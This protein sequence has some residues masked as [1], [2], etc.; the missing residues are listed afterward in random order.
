MSDTEEKKKESSDEETSDE[1]TS[2]SIDTEEA[3]E[4]EWESVALAFSECMCMYH[5][6]PDT[7]ALFIPPPLLDPELCDMDN[8]LRFVK[9]PSDPAEQK[10]VIDKLL[11]PDTTQVKGMVDGDVVYICTDLDG[12][13]DERQLFAREMAAAAFKIQPEVYGPMIY[14]PKRKSKV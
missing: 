5:R 12:E 3:E 8:G 9:W 14:V 11:G 2:S 13:S 7:K 6:C 1:E 4:E 10:T